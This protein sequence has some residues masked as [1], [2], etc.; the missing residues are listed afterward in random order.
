MWTLMR[1]W[2]LSWEEGSVGDRGGQETSCPPY[3]E[4]LLNEVEHN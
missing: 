3:E 1:L 4:S 2:L